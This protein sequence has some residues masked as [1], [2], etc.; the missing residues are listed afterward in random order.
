MVRTRHSVAPTRETRAFQ[1]GMTAPVV[2]SRAARPRVLATPFTLVKS[3]AMISL[4]SGVRTMS[5]TRPTMRGRKVVIQ[6][7]SRSNAASDACGVVAPAGPCWTPVK[8]P[9][10]NTRVGVDSMASTF[11]FQGSTFCSSTWF[12]P[13]TPHGANFERSS[14]PAGLGAAGYPPDGMEGKA[15]VLANFGRS[16][17]RVNGMA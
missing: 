16:H 17:T 9:P 12:I 14:S 2:G 6:L 3:P 5:H 15:S 7:P 11:V 1:P 10:T 8:R 13:L 4:L